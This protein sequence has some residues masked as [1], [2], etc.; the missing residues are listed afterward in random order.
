MNKKVRIALCI[1]REGKYS[2]AGF[3]PSEGNTIEEHEE[4]L[5]E[6]ASSGIGDDLFAKFYWIEL[7]VEVPQKEDISILKDVILTEVEENA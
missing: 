2:A 4:G 3:D 1:N 6:I 5:L 7:E